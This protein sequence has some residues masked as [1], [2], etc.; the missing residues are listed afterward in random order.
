VPTERPLDCHLQ[1]AGSYPGVADGEA[2]A[3][4]VGQQTA[5]RTGGITD[6]AAYCA[7]HNHDESHRELLGPLLPGSGASGLVVHHGWV[8]AEWGDPAVPEMAFSATKTMVS[9]VA[10]LAFDDGLLDPHAPVADTVALDALPPGSAITW[11]HL[12]QQTSGWDGEL[13][14]RPAAVDA[15]SRRDPRGHPGGP[16]GSAWAYNDVRV[17]LL[18]LALTALWR[19][20]LP[21]VFAERIMNPLGASTTWTWHGYPGAVLDLDGH[22]LPV[23]SGGAHWGGGLWISAHDLALVGQLVLG[24]GAWRGRQLLSPAWIRQSWNPCTVNPAYGYLWWLNQ[25]RTVFPDAPATGL[26]A[27]G[28]L[29]R[30]LLWIDPARDLVVVS[31]WGDDVG[32]LLREVSA[33]VAG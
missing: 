10:G 1:Q 7:V 21:E 31:R 17:N 18:C 9:L 12:L 8:I 2:V 20:P 4:A 26:C 30:H 32:R 27:R 16:P 14:G 28:N 24:G 23:V 25:T 33:A 29:G 6:M 19:R 22:Q 13:W 5:R 11:Q 15:Q 3:T